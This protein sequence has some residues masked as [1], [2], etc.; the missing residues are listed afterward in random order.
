MKLADNIA[1][2]LGDEPIMD[3]IV[4]CASAAAF[5]IKELPAEQ[6]EL[7]RQTVHKLIDEMLEAWAPET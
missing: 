6:R 3:V 4:G 1:D 5:A 7:G 2:L